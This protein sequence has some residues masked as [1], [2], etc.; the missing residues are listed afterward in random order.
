M[1]LVTALKSDWKWHAILDKIL[2]VKSSTNMLEY[3][4][5]YY[6]MISVWIFIVT[7][8]SQII[9]WGFHFSNICLMVCLSG[10]YFH[11]QVKKNSHQYVT[12]II[13]HSQNG[14]EYIAY[15]YIYIFFFF[16][17]KSK[18]HLKILVP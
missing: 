7:F 14:P 11:T 13:Q 8:L 10:T 16:F 9:W 3:I 5:L 6:N 1:H 15:I 18:R 17:Q 12:D 2:Y 4:I